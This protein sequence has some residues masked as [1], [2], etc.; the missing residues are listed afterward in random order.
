MFHVLAVCSGNA[1][2][3]ILAEA[4]LNRDGAGRVRAWSAGPMPKGMVERPALDLLA[5]RGV[6]TSGLRSKGWAEFQDPSAPR[7]DLVLSLCPT[8][9]DAVH[10]GWHGDPAE[11]RWLIEDPSHAPAEQAHLAFQHTYHRLS[12][13]IN[14]FLALPFERLPRRDL[15]ERLTEIGER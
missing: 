8:V 15:I 9:A 7:M 11:A 14:A 5:R 12:A 6:E 3:S 2:R 10:P 13:W 4:I 1:S